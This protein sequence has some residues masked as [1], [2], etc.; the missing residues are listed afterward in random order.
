M[1]LIS[2]TRF[3]IRS[4]LYLIMVGWH[5]YWSYKQLSRADGFL[6]SKFLRETNWSVFW[7]VTAWKNKSCMNCYKN[8]GAH[9]Q[10]MPWLSLMC[11]EASLV[12]WEQEDATLPDWQ[13]VRKRM[14]EN[15]RFYN[16]SNPSKNHVEHYITFPQISQV[17]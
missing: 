13:T 8:I 10:A 15:G 16:L 17:E 3:R 2:G 6:D 11:N 12:H 4:P 7:S 14:L 5:S 1:V 9:R